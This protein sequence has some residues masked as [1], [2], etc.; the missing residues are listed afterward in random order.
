MG[1][2][3][4]HE[5]FFNLFESSSKFWESNTTTSDKVKIEYTFKPSSREV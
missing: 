4:K 2:D 1:K 3:I 5:I